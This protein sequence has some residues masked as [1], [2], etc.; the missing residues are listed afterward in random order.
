VLEDPNV[1]LVNIATC[2]HWRAPA[3][4]FACQAGKHVYV[5][6]PVSHNIWGGRQMARAARKYNRIVQGG[7]QRRSNGYVRR[8]VELL[9]QG[10]I[11][12]VYM[13][14][15]LVFGDRGSIGFRDAE[16]PPADG[17]AEAGR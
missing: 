1:D 5:E 14:R 9:G 6:K 17:D 10:V 15:A 12:D 8:A 3:A 11:G 7:T 13:A 16:Q 2:S 4:I